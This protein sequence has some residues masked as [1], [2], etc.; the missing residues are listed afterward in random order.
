MVSPEMSVATVRLLAVASLPKNRGWVPQETLLARVRAHL[1]TLDAVTLN[2]ALFDCADVVTD[3]G[4]PQSWRLAD[5]PP[6]QRTA[7]RSAA[8]GDASTGGGESTHAARRGWL[9]QGG[10][11]AVISP[12]KVCL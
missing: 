8:G 2:A 5:H 6:L 12:R 1:P 4:D 9:R 11:R 3:A 7:D 10:S